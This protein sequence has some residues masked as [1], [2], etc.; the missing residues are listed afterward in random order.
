MFPG[1]LH[2]RTADT[3]DDGA[4][5]FLQAG[6]AETGEDDEVV[7]VPVV[8]G[9]GDA[10][11]AEGAIA[12]SAVSDFVSVAGAGVTAAVGGDDVSD[13]AEGRL[14]LM[15]QPDPLKTTPAAK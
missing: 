8:A 3:L 11:A 6:Y 4:H 13:G 14:S 7:P 12:A 15:Y 10:G 5:D 1:N 9:A 2:I